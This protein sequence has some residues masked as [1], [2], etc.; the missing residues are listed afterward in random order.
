LELLE[1][2]ELLAAFTAGDIVVSRVGDG[3][4]ALNSSATATFLDEYNPSTQA[5]VQS[6]A[7]PTSG[8]SLTEI[9]NR[10]SGGRVTAS[11]DGHTLS[12]AG[13]QQ[14]PGGTI[15]GVDVVVGVVNPD[16]TIDATTKISP[17]DLLSS[18]FVGSTAS[19]DGLGF[20]VATEH[21]LRY[22][23]FGNSDLTSS[24]AVSNFFP[25]PPATAIS[26]AGQL[27]VD[28][29]AGA[30]SNGVPA[31]DGPATIGTGLP[32]NAGQTGTVLAGFPT[33]RDSSGNFPSPEQFVISPDGNTIFVADNRT[34]GSGGILE[35]FQSIPGFWTEVGNLQAGSGAD[36]GLR[37]LAADFSGSAPVLYATTTAGSANRVVEITGG[38]LDG[39]A[40]SFSITTLATA[41]TN[42][43]FTGVAP[44]PTAAGTSPSITSLT[45]SGDPGTYGTGDTLT[46]TMDAAETGWISFQQNG[47]EIGAA[48]LVSGTATFTTAGN[49]PG[50]TYS[51]V[52][53]YTGDSTFAPS[54][55]TAQS[56]TINQATTTTT[57]TEQA[58]PVATGVPDTLTATI[59]SVPAGTAPTGTVTFTDTT[60]GTTLGTVPVTQIIVNQ[61]GNPVIE[62]VATLSASFSTTGTDTVTATY[63]GDTNFS[64]STGTDNVTIVNSTTTT[65]TTSNPNPTAN[66]TGSV[67]LTATVTSQ[68]GTP[69]GSVEFF[70]NLLPFLGATITSAT[71]SG[72]T[73]TITA[74][75]NVPFS[76]GQTVAITGV[77]VGGY[78][79]VFTISGVSTNTFQYTVADPGLA[80]GSGGAAGLAAT[81][82]SNGQASATINTALLQ[83]GAGSADVL[84]PGLHSISA[85]YTPDAAGANSFFTSTGVYEQAVQAQ[86]FASGDVFVYRVGDGQTRLIAP[87]NNP[88]S[89]TAAIGS[90][91][92]VDEYTPTGTLVQSIILPS[93]DGSTSVNISTAT[94]SGTTVTVTTVGPHGLEQGETVTIAGASVDGYNGTFTITG[95]TST[96]FTYRAASGLADATGGTAS[97]NTVHAVVGNGQQS[98]TE[99]MTLSGDGQFL[100]LVGYDTNP[101]NT[102][103]APAIPTG[104]G[105]GNVPRA[106]ARIK[107]DGTVDTVGMSGVQTGGNFNGVYSPDGH[108]FYVSGFNGVTYFSSFVPTASLQTATT[109]ITSTNFTVLGLEA[110]GSDL[111]AIGA[112]SNLVQK[113]TGFPTSGTALSALPGV[114]TATDPNQTFV[115]DAYFTHLNGTGAPAGIN[116]MYLSDDGP[117]FANGEITKWAFDGSNWNLVDHITAGTGNSAISF[118][119]MAGATD[120]SGNVTLYVTYG[121][122]GNADTGPGQL[123][124]ITDTN[125]WNALIGTGGTHSDAAPVVAAVGNTSNEV[126]RGVA[127]APVQSGG[128]GGG[129]SPH[130]GGQR[131]L[132]PAPGIGTP[133]P[134]GTL[135]LSGQTGAALPGGDPGA[136]AGGPA[137]PLAGGDNAVAPGPLPAPAPGL[138]NSGPATQPQSVAAA[139]SLF[140][141]LGDADAPDAVAALRIGHRRRHFLG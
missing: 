137:A 27:Y 53:V 83:A 49:L 8:N 120:S 48:P 112:S 88:N 62:F 40:P 26:P 14:A 98:A 18:E 122:G 134:A 65:V 101:L 30:Q 37:G 121:N 28:G 22:V 63:N 69:T 124:S 119:W 129:G 72:G 42:E 105:S 116:T 5:L 130:R 107:F 99:Q 33:S 12:I 133:P 96:T 52:A 106:V 94:E 1:Q 81:L 139:D 56:V 13:Y 75:N 91:I 15:S 82:D 138:T 7:L 23:P 39:S 80:N 44:A 58:N 68:G 79:G 135:L 140:T 73:V 67:T 136:A 38:T 90:T 109:S 4:A 57:L 54:T 51:V 74:A 36:S 97:N 128:G 78:N 125:G 95:V 16:G 10:S 110:D 66:P 61:A 24:T 86:A 84:T 126:F 87:P 50:G 103:T 93:A 2:R 117:G 92:F 64:S 70:D 25:F 17:A 102:A 9:G 46:A 141:V 114:S 113:Y 71:D 41:A 29:G 31:I 77:N 132:A 100:F 111:A 76:N 6:I 11:A 127:F 85:I 115:I 123:Y 43:V 118:Y 45:V 89:G 131:A 34:D 55:S 21:F 35:F 47:V 104:P 20:W 3:S 59:G 108:Q 60:T 19:A 32:T